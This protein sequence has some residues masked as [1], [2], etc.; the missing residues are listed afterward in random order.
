MTRLPALSLFINTLLI[1]CV[2]FFVCLKKI[3]IYLKK[4]KVTPPTVTGI[5]EQCR[6]LCDKSIN[7]L[8]P[9]L[10]PNG[11]KRKNTDKSV[12]HSIT[13]Y[14]LR[15]KYNNNYGMEANKINK[16]NENK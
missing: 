14:L 4:I 7:E 3:K 8:S 1:F 15:K 2:V 6:L 13:I 11:G 5:D 16:S 9:E 12:S 10:L